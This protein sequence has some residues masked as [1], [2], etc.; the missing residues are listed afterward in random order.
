VTTRS[1]GDQNDVRL[2]VEPN[3]VLTAATVV[4]TVTDPA[5]TVTNPTVTSTSL[6]V[7]DASFTLN[8]AGVWFWYFTTSGAVVGVT[9]TESVLAASPEPN[10]YAS[11]ADLKSYLGL[12]DLTSDIQLLDCLI[13]SARSIEHICGRKFFAE[14]TAS[15]R[16][17]APAGTDVVRVDDFWTTTGLVVAIDSSDTG[18]Y[19]TTIAAANYELEPF[20]N[21]VDGETGWPYYQ[22]RS[23]LCEFLPW[24]RRRASVQVTAKWGWSAVPGPVRQANIYLAEE[25]LKMKDSPFGVA[26]FDQFGPVRVRENPKVLAMLAPYRL[27]PVLVA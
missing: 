18:T 1:V 7:Y 17:F 16:V 5:G 10:T 9:P 20:N 13:T 27:N 21:N 8:L 25:T 12:T 19:A 6:G 11:L 15:A 4:L 26:G 14:Q 23:L 24:N 2:V 3:G 22:I